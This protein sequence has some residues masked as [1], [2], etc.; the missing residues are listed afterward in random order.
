[1]DEGKRFRFPDRPP[2]TAYDWALVWYFQRIKEDGSDP[3]VFSEA[4]L[5]LVVQ[6]AEAASSKIRQ[7]H[8]LDALDR[9]VKLVESAHDELRRSPDPDNVLYGLAIELRNMRDRVVRDGVIEP[10]MSGGGFLPCRYCGGL[11]KVSDHGGE[12][13]GCPECL[14]NGFVPLNTQ[15]RP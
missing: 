2:R 4:A 8:L 6:M 5:N 1:M 13:T 11:K 3:N 7:D 15:L 9:A 14:G 12:F 10:P